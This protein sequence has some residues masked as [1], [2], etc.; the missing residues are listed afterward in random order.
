MK[1]DRSIVLNLSSLEYKAWK[2][3]SLNG[4]RTHDLCNIGAALLPIELSSQPEAAH[5]VIEI[6][7]CP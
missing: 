4:I 3:S 7:N 6:V 2:N 5:F 1:D